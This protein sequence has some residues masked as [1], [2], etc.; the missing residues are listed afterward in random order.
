MSGTGRPRNCHRSLRSAFTLIEV[1]VVLGIAG[2]LVGISVPAVLSARE[3]VRHTA[4]QSH[5]R[6]MVLAAQLYHDQWQVYPVGADPHLKLLPNLGY[7][8]VAVEIQRA[9]WSSSP[10]RHN[11]PIPVYRC[12]TDPAAPGEGVTNYL[13]NLGSAP[14]HRFYNGMVESHD[15]R[16]SAR[17]ITDGQS[18][19][20]IYAELLVSDFRYSQPYSGPPSHPLRVLWYTSR[21]YGRL[22]EMDLYADDCQDQSSV[23]PLRT[24]VDSRYYSDTSFKGFT[25]LLPPNH[26]SCANGPYPQGVFES[27]ELTASSLHG[28]GANAAFVDGHVQFMA[29][30]IDRGLWRALATRQGGEVVLP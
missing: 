8:G 5:L 2:L 6:Q 19:T 7:A 25:S 16:T 11:T 22:D 27:L 1:L 10:E 24:S 3:R 18:S 26:L 17:D 4:C 13:Q 12:P 9:R 14:L 28:S 29:A 21:T 23:A 20:L 30:S 15:S